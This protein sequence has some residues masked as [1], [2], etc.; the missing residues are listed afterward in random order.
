MPKKLERVHL[1]C[2]EI[3][4]LEEG[5]ELFKRLSKVGCQCNEEWCKNE[6]LEVCPSCSLGRLQNKLFVAS[7][8]VLHIEEGSLP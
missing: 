5:L 7:E 6:E 8:V 2:E 4:V 3:Q 1:E